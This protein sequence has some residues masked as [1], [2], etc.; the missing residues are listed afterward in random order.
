MFEVVKP[1]KSGYLSLMT[2]GFFF[3]NVFLL[4][5]NSDFFLLIGQGG[6]NFLVSFC[7]D[8]SNFYSAMCA[9]LRGPLRVPPSKGTCLLKG[10]FTYQTYGIH[11]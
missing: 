8:I 5:K 1:L 7:S 6:P 2:L 9:L 4:G 3:L 10:Q 11:C